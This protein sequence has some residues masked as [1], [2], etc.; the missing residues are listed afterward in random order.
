MDNNIKNS[1]VLAG[2]AIAGGYGGSWVA[3]RLCDALGCSLGPWGSAIGAMLGA[4][5]GTA[6]ANSMTGD[7]QILPEFDPEAVAE[8]VAAEAE[9]I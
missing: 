4:M 8:A 2:S 6:V 9:K 1:L 5:A 3:Q 7:K